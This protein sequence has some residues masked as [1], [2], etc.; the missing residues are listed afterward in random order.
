MDDEG[1]GWDERIQSTGLGWDERI[2]TQGLGWDEMEKM[3]GDL[4]SRQLFGL[5]VSS[6]SVSAGIYLF[7]VE[8][9]CKKLF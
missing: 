8:I 4:I 9:I 7:S 1:S 5:T 3:S 2:R 6:G